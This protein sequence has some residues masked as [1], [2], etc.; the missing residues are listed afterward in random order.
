LNSLSVPTPTPLRPTTSCRT[1]T[2]KSLKHPTGCG[3][4]KVA[5]WFCDSILI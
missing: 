5:R 1:G 4:S 2:P 3:S